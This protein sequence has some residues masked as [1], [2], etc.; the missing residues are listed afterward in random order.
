[1]TRMVIGSV[2]GGIAMWLV[3]FLFWGTPLSRF[4]LTIADE[5]ANAAIQSALAQ[6]LGSTGT[7]AYPVPWP[8]TPAAT[9]LYGQGPTAMVFYNS[10]GFPVFDSAA[11][12]GGLVLAIICAL[13]IG[14]ALYTLSGR[15]T[16]FADR[17]KLVI[18][19]ALA[20]T[21]YTDIGQPIYN[22]MP[23]SYFI[24]L[25]LS[26]VVALVVAGAVI[27]RWFLPQ[28]AVTNP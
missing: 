8:G 18:L 6:H 13:L 1:M 11:L 25:W 3:G 28:P 27:A 10:S 20:A 23:W 24:Y 19:F 14:T 5:P 21:L 2:L 26:N 4:A 16:S 7:G 22:H 17:V 12:I 15:V 9:V